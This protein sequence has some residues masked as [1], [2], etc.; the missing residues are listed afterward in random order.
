MG[1]CFNKGNSG[2]VHRNMDEKKEVKIRIQGNDEMTTGGNYDD[3]MD[4]E[5]AKLVNPLPQKPTP[6][7][8]DH[9][10][11]LA[12][13]RWR[14]DCMNQVK[15]EL[16]TMFDVIAKKVDSLEKHLDRECKRTDADKLLKSTFLDY[17]DSCRLS[18]DRLS[19]LLTRDQKRHQNYI[20][21]VIN[22]K[23]A[24]EQEVERSIS[25]YRTR[26]DVSQI[27]EVLSSTGTAFQASH[28]AGSGP[29]KKTPLF[30]SKKQSEDL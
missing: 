10:D 19:I 12:I 25:K 5:M 24:W 17:Q 8:D 3:K 27:P 11:M 13:A 4:P 20:D 6:G 18:R 23:K 29:F 2:K 30:G 15:E 28:S 26:M 1:N 7:K 21:E 14:M 16:E 22:K 9:Q